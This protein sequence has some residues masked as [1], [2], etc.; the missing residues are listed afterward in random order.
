MPWRREWTND[1]IAKLKSMAGKVRAE[2]IAA[3]LGRTVGSTAVKAHELRIS[4]RY[5][6]K[7]TPKNPDASPPS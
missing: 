2:V 6:P 4:L 1:D 5:L 7:G 3:E